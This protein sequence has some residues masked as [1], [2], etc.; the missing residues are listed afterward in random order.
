LI[1]FHGGALDAEVTLPKQRD[2]GGY[3]LLWD[4]AW[5]LPLESREVVDPGPI[6]V[7]GASIRVYSLAQ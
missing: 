1:V 2:G 5:D 7:T 4:S 6:T 3:R